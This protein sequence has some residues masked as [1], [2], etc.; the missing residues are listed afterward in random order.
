MQQKPLGWATILSDG[1][2]CFWCLFQSVNAYEKKTSAS[3]SIS[4]TIQVISFFCTIDDVSFWFLQSTLQ[5]LSFAMSF[6]LFRYKR[7]E[8]CFKLLILQSPLEDLSLFDT[9]ISLSILQSQLQDLSK[10]SR[11]CLWS[12]FLTFNHY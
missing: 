8:L 2:G 7:S 12:K 1:H 9:D 10:L 6:S 4:V 3:Q 5:D 11:L